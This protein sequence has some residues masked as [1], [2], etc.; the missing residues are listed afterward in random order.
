MIELRD[1]E[2]DTVS[3]FYLDHKGDLYKAANI[4]AVVNPWSE[5]AR[6]ILYSNDYDTICDIVCRGTIVHDI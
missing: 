5:S 6:Y 1:K 2:L 4:I 3:R